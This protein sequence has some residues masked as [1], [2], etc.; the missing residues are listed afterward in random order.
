MEFNVSPV[1][2]DVCMLMLH[3]DYR[4][5]TIAGILLSN[6]RINY[7]NVKAVCN[8]LACSLPYH[9]VVFLTTLIAK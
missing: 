4:K 3:T 2:V 8:N 6:I 7:L 9:N 1:Y 5:L